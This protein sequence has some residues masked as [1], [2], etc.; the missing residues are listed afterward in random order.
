MDAEIDIILDEVD[1]NGD[2]V[3]DFTEFVTM[4]TKMKTPA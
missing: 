4:M 3:V 2:G 1:K